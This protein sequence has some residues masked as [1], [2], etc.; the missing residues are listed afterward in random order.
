[1]SAFVPE[2]AANDDVQ[3]QADAQAMSD[4]LKQVE[5]PSA[6]DRLAASREHMREWML[7]ADGRRERRRRAEA[8]AAA[9]HKPPIVDRLRDIPVLGMV[10]DAL[11]AWWSGHPLHSVAGMAQGAA[12]QRLAPLARRHPLATMA[13]AFV[14]GMLVVRLKPWRWLAKSAVF[15]GVAGQVIARA[16][17]AVPLESLIGILLA[18][19]AASPPPPEESAAAAE[20]AAS[21]AASSTQAT[22]TAAASGSGPVGPITPAAST[23][24]AEP[25]LR[26]ASAQVGEIA[27]PRAGEPLREGATAP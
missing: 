17:A 18:Q 27:P 4:A 14:V 26:T 11:S 24:A 16:I 5:L 19:R 25:P 2:S 7:E 1:M 20:A 23:S 10:V 8:A 15:A 6:A 21:A 12:H 9:G 22:A 3:A 13:G